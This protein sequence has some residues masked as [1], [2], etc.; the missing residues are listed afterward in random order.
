MKKQPT[1][2]GWGWLPLTLLTTIILHPLLGQPIRGHDFN[3]HFY[4]I[5]I[6]NAMWEQG[7]WFSRWSPD[8]TL[9]YG[10]PLFNFYP[11][12]S[13]YLL[14]INYWLTGQHAPLAYNLSYALALI[15]GAIG[16]FLLGRWLYGPAGGLLASAA[17]SFSPLLL[18]QTYA[19]GSLSNSWVLAL[20]PWAA[21]AL[22]ILVRQPR[23]GRA[24]LAIILLASLPL[25]HIAAG[26]IQLPALLLLALAGLTT[27]KKIHAPPRFGATLLMLGGV[28]LAG[29]A[30][31]AFF[32]LPAL[33]EISYTYYAQAANEV[34]F[35]DHFAAVWHWPPRHLAGAI[36]PY[37]P[38]SPGIG[39]M[40]LAFGAG[41]V[42]WG[43]WLSYSR[44]SRKENHPSEQTLLATRVA[45][46]SLLLGGAGLFL[47]TTPSYWLW[48]NIPLLTNW[49]FPW[50]FL[51]LPTF[52]FALTSGYAAY[53]LSQ[54][55]HWPPTL[56]QLPLLL[57]GGA[58]TL[59]F[60]NAI[61]YL[62]PPVVTDLPQRLTPAEATDAQQRYSIYGL[63]GWS[64]YTAS[65]VTA[66]PAE[67]LFVGA[68]NQ[69]PLAAKTIAPDLPAQIITS[70]PWQATWQFDAPS[71]TEVT[72]AHHYFPGW[73][74]TVNGHAAPLGPDELGRMQFTVPAGEHLV[75]LAW[76]QTPVRRW[77][78][79]VTSTAVLLLLALTLYQLTP[80]YRRR[81]QPTPTTPTQPSPPPP[82]GW[83]WFTLLPL[84][85]L[86]GKVGWLDHYPSPW[87]MHPGPDGTV[88]GLTTPAS[89]NFDDKI[90]LLGYELLE[91][92]QLTLYWQAQRD[93]DKA[94]HVHIYLRNALG[95]PLHTIQNSTPGLSAT[96]SWQAG[97]V[98]RDVYH[99]PLDD[100][101]APLVYRVAVSVQ[102]TEGEPLPLLDGPDG[103]TRVRLGS[104]QLAEVDIAI[105]NS[106]KPI[107]AEFGKAIAL[108]HAAW[109]PVVAS[110]QA[111]DLT[112]YWES[113]TAVSENYTV[114]VH[115][116][117]QQGTLQAGNDGP[118]RQ[119]LYPTSY[120]IPG[121]TIA[122]RRQ[123]TVDLPPGK[124]PLHIGLYQRESGQRLP[125]TTADAPH[126]DSVKIG[127]LTIE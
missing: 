44:Q 58:I 106:A 22:L 31:S 108:T 76:G 118:P 96:N 39:Q 127:Y 29:L 89:G 38:L 21:W 103:A 125:L 41:L 86:L 48:E 70:D 105:P 109:P 53:R 82:F 69:A 77:A 84:L 114:F 80:P 57:L 32:W 20:L 78:N 1:T 121:E 101:L 47:A 115:L 68:D 40:L 34:P 116:Y 65:T 88:A 112:L 79:G 24:L 55:N 63:I 124:Y 54:M 98:I 7:I 83:R 11:P 6:I 107:E 46:L 64:E 91:P 5:P 113:L 13:A 90:Q 75:K 25:F 43:S 14:T 27:W 51:D 35:A 17:Y 42:A 12:L 16:M 26:L 102:E 67:P 92:D 100:E 126:A 10:S 119:G 36:N 62:Y 85:L 2:W 111:F 123:W 4:R 45:A 120:W 19:R 117:D 122:S 23:I 15:T 8:L 30:L 61:P 110:G 52:F 97:H 37:W 28:L 93:L 56:K 74:L 81:A 50:R 73:Q 95:V 66:W 18:Y 60:V 104:T 3:L 33:S 99:L 72:L 71:G 9:G 59:F 49:Q 94:Y 87:L